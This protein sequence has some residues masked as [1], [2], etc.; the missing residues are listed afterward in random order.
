MKITICDISEAVCD[1]CRAVMP[2]DIEVLHDSILS[3]P[4]DA[5]VSPANSFG[6][7]DGGIDAAY[8]R[9]FGVGVQHRLQE[10]IA[11]ETPFGELLV[12]QAVVIPTDDKQ[13]PY[14]VA[15]P[16]MRVPMPIRDPIDILLATRAAIIALIPFGVDTLAIPGMGT[17]A[18]M[19]DPATAARAMAT[20]IDQGLHAVG[21]LWHPDRF[22][23]SWRQAYQRHISLE[24]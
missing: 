16:T 17:G 24:A 7:M 5:I 18:G 3:H 8:T 10:E 23:T 11:L 19:V 13:I 22:P 4:W 12:G 14:L 15:A 21:G 20:G 6:F 2:L 1:A 9:R